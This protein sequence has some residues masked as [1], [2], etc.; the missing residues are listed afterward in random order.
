[1]AARR[2]P[3]DG[4]QGL[5][6][7]KARGLVA[8]AGAIA[9]SARGEAI[10]R[11][12]EAETVPMAAQVEERSWSGCCATTPG[13]ARRSTSWSWRAV[14]RRNHRHPRVPQPLPALRA[15]REAAE[16]RLGVQGFHHQ[17]RARAVR[18]P[19]DVRAAV[20]A[21]V[22]RLPESSPLWDATG[23]A[24]RRN[25]C[26][27]GEIDEPLSRLLRPRQPVP[28]AV[29]SAAPNRFIDSFYDIITLIF[30]YHYQ[31]NKQD[32]RQRNEVAIREHLTYIDALLSRNVA[33]WSRTRVPRAS[34]SARE[35]ATD[36]LPSPRSA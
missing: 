10:E 23:G 24:A 36:R 25:T 21:G 14:R 19:R 32:E 35:T 9:A 15:D 26:A 7:L 30:H 17:L 22:G 16:C 6:A 20:G 18:D 4:A 28:P 8:G 13:R 27:A 11:F 33:P 31:W 34:G 12:P 1:M 29:N 5:A 2:E 3:H